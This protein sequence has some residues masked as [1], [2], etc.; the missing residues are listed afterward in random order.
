MI[1]AEAVEIEHRH[2]VALPQRAL[3]AVQQRF[4]PLLIAVVVLADIMTVG[5]VIR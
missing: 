1:D 5:A 2:V 4:L 3:A